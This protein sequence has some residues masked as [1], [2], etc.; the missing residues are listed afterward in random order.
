M[1]YS[2]LMVEVFMALS[3]HFYTTDGR[4]KP[5]YLRDKLNTQDDPLDEYI[6]HGLTEG[7][8]NAICEKSSG[9]LISCLSLILSYS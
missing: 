6:H 2:D 8:K 7:I 1:A 5:Y 3:E 9:P 4:P